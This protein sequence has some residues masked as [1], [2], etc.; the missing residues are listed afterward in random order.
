MA[1]FFTSL[2]FTV[3]LLLGFTSAT[4]DLSCT[5]LQTVSETLNLLYY[6]GDPFQLTSINLTY[7]NISSNFYDACSNLVDP[8]EYG[9][10]FLQ[11]ESE[12]NR[13]HHGGLRKSRR[14]NN[15][16][17]AISSIYSSFL[18]IDI[19]TDFG[20][21]TDTSVGRSRSSKKNKRKNNNPSCH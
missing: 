3:T 15:K 7:Y 13:P 9:E 6:P 8:G 11:V 5:N 21:D 4:F 2:F 10:S 18:E 16:Q 19:D 12:A 14:G 17:T 1:K 20:I